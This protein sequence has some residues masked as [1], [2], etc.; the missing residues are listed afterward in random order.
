[1]IRIDEL[2]N[3]LKDYEDN[4]SVLP[5]LESLVNYHL[6]DE[7]VFHLNEIIHKKQQQINYRL[8]NINRS[9]RTQLTFDKMYLKG[10]IY[11]TEQVAKENVG[12]QIRNIER[13]L[14]N[15]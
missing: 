14:E 5:L 13:T 6:D 11:K 4:R 9:Y 15:V 1:M 8:L 12:L 10:E 2:R 7:E 3:M